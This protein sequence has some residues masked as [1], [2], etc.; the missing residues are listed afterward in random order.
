MFLKQPN[1]QN[2]DY[3]LAW[4]DGDLCNGLGLKV[5]QILTFY[6]ATKKNVKSSGFKKLRKYKQFSKTLTSA[7]HK[8]WRTRRSTEGMEIG[9]LWKLWEKH[10]CNTSSDLSAK[11]L[12]MKTKLKIVFQ[13]K[14]EIRKEIPALRGNAAMSSDSHNRWNKYGKRDG[15]NRGILWRAPYEK[16]SISKTL[17]LMSET[18][19]KLQWWKS[20]QIITAEEL[21]EDPDEDSLKYWTND[22]RESGKIPHRLQIHIRHQREEPRVTQQSCFTPTPG[23]GGTSLPMYS[24]N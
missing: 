10:I 24:D 2:T 17:L 18:Q 7:G 4:R 13:K 19:K 6:W 5:E 3:S 1:R 20:P 23:G 9:H 11:K 12:K 16:T 21:C 15:R 14:H 8:R 22:A